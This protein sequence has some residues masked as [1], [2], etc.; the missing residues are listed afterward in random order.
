MEEMINHPVLDSGTSS[1]EIMNLFTPEFYEYLKGKPG[2]VNSLLHLFKS[3]N[4]KAGEIITYLLGKPL[5]KKDQHI[6]T[7]NE[8]GYHSATYDLT[9]TE[10]KIINADSAEPSVEFEIEAMFSEPEKEWVIEAYF[11]VTKKDSLF[12]REFV[13]KDIS[14][15]LKEKG[16]KIFR[17]YTDK[18]K[19]P[20]R[21]TRELK[22]F[23]CGVDPEHT[24]INLTKRVM[25]K[26]TARIV[27]I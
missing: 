7:L 8:I 4:E 10:P 16:Y 20:M 19:G 14:L 26:F 12:R 18:D 24:H 9:W 21:T 27:P 5:H 13:L 2:A 6:K 25:G 22:F 23:T 17:F 11:L 1:T 3:G 15:W